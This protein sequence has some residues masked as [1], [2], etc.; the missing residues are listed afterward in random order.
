MSK[1]FELLQ[2]AAKRERRVTIEVY[3]SG[4]F[5]IYANGEYLADGRDEGVLV[6]KLSKDLVNSEVPDDEQW[7]N[8]AAAFEGYDAEFYA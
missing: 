5:Y 4:N 3:G 6:A 1:L 2:E 8:R 7:E